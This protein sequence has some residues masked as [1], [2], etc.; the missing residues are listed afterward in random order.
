MIEYTIAPFIIMGAFI[1]EY[2][3]KLKKSEKLAEARLDLIVD[4]QE[5][6]KEL[7]KTNLIS[8]IKY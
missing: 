6:I 8:S 7:E 4:Y 5:K 3:T 2:Y 1:F